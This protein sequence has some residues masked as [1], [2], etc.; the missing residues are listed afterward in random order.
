MRMLGST[1]LEVS[2]ICLGTAMFGMPEIGCDAQEAQGIF[3]AYRARGGNFVDTADS[4]GTGAS[5]EIVGRL[6]RGCRDEVVLATKVGQR[7]GEGTVGLSRDR[8]LSAVDAS[9]RRLGTDHIDL[10]LMHAVDP[11]APMDET[12]EA[13]DACVR[14]G[15]VRA[16][17]CSNIEAWRLARALDTSRAHGWTPFS[18]VQLR[19]NLLAR[20]I[21]REHLPLCELDGL[22]VTAFNPLSSGVLSG[23]VGPEGPPPDSR[24]AKWSY[25]APLLSGRPVELAAQ[26]REIAGEIGATAAQVA[27][28]WTMDRP[29]ITAAISG[30][31]LAAQM[32]ENMAALDL[33]LPDDAVARLDALSATPL[34]HP[35][36]DIMSIEAWSL[37]PEGAEPPRW[38][39]AWVTGR[40]RRA[41][42]GS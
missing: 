22:A 21:E 37:R 30:A 12:L 23:K 25:Y 14:A 8:I 35:Y 15:K 19:Y 4:Y 31:R 3:D 9:L 29:G 41:S 33:E 24:L 17:G 2:P 7:S 16:L 11:R 39:A 1:G 27:L 40:E 5:E 42:P 32:D 10:Y 38:P 13:L 6:L 36:D 28:A 18:C 26:V 20:E 34:G